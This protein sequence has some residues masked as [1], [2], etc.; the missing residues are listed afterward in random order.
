MNAVLRCA[1]QLAAGGVP[2]FFCRSTK[3][4]ACPDG[5]KAA[6]DDPAALRRLWRCFPGP[7]IG[8]PTGAASGW[9]VLDIDPA[10]G[11][12]RWWKEHRN[13]IPRTR[14]HRT[15]SG[16]AHVFF[17][18]AEG[19]RNTAGRLGQGVDTRASGGYVVWWPAT[20]LQAYDLP[21]LPWPDWMLAKLRRAPPAAVVHRPEQASF[22][23]GGSRYGLA[24][25]ERECDAIQS[26]PFGA[27][28]ATLNGAGFKIGA[29][30][31]GG[32][33]EEG[34][35]IASLIAAG[36]SIPSQAGR[37]PWRQDEVEAKLRR[38]YAD[39]KRSPRSASRNRQEARRV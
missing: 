38:A 18:H 7:L 32:E 30:V 28:E 22:D 4:P 1:E 24:A 12:G 35:A 27:Q 11:G 39:G 2:V 26:A 23:R 20:G 37:P 6:T 21:T 10:H 17:R 13:E 5:F 15:R 8:V 34:I 25:L 36:W 31:A 3:A 33:L 9:D 19:M 16:G 29:L 14:F